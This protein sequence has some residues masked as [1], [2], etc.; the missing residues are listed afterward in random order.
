MTVKIL[1][2][3]VV[4]HIVS[5]AGKKKE[6][7]L[8]C[9]HEEKDA[10]YFKKHNKDKIIQEKSTISKVVFDGSKIGHL[11]RYNS[12]RPATTIGG[13]QII[14][15]GQPIFI[16]KH[17]PRFNVDALDFLFEVGM[18]IDWVNGNT[19]STEIKPVAIGD[20]VKDLDVEK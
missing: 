7:I 2:D 17:T 18:A 9:F 15:H 14:F 3:V 19:V 6:E 20:W 4:R 12:P 16:N 10:E 1:H 11:R 5:I 8:G 13:R